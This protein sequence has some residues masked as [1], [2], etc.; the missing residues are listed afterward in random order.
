MSLSTIFTAAERRRKTLHRYGS[1]TSDLADQFAGR[2]VAVE[3]HSLPRRG[4]PPFVIIKEDDDFL[5]AVSDEE[6]QSFLSPTISPPWRIDEAATEYRVLYDLLDNTG[7]SSL[8]RQQL[9]ATSREIEDRAYRVGRGRFHV[10]FQWSAAFDPQKDFYR[11]LAADTD[12]DIHVS[13]VDEPNGELPGLTVHVE[14]TPEI[15]R[16]WTMAF[17]ADGDT[18]QQCGLVARQQNGTYEG[19][20]T[21]DPPLVE[22][23]FESLSGER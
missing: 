21:Y 13:L 2:N 11:R 17:D 1:E 18:S 16:Y 14:P 23:V 3:H 5:G 7:F 12:L 20:W 22:R 8:D 15:G 10:S 19:V 4:P 6:L 9:L